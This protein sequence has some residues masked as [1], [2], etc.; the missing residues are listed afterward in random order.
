MIYNIT[1]ISQEHDWGKL[2][3]RRQRLRCTIVKGDGFAQDYLL[4]LPK[5]VLF[6]IM[7]Y[8]VLTHWMLGEALQT[9]EVVWLDDREPSRH[10]EHSMYLV[11]VVSS[12]QQSLSNALQVTW[13]A[14]PLWGATALILLMTGVCW[15][16]FTYRR[17]GFIPQ[18]F[19]SIRTLCAATTQLAAFPRTGIQWGD[20]GEGKQFRHAGLSAD[21]VGKIVPNELYAGAGEE[22]EEK[23]GFCCA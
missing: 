16:A 21:E 8:S 2:E 22:G 6:P 20:L 14:Y 11:S 1:I 9:Q 10:V 7:F 18:M 15:W 23:T 5:R 13:A 12:L 17:E 19:G 3:H 4:Q